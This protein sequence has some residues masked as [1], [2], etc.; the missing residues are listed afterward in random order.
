MADVV[1]HQRDRLAHAF[2]MTGVR[3][4]AKHRPRG[5]RKGLTALGPMHA[6]PPLT[7]G[8]AN[9][10][11]HFRRPSYLLSNWTPSHTELR[12]ARNP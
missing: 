3:G 5:D 4:V 10:A 9:R 6:A 1:T 12:F 7:I 2:L 8:T 11:A